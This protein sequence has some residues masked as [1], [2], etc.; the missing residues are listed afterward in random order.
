VS[1][2]RVP[3]APFRPVW[4]QA[5]EGAARIGSGGARAHQRATQEER[6]VAAGAARRT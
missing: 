2:S 6:G 5:P 1:A 4:P 3:L